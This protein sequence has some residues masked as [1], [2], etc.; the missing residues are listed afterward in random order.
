[1]LPA[2]PLPPSPAPPGANV[3]PLPQG[4]G[5]GTHAG[6][7]GGVHGGGHGS[8]YGS[9]LGAVPGPGRTATPQPAALPPGTASAPLP[10]SGPS[11]ATA[12][13]A[14]A[15][16]PQL[17]LPATADRAAAALANGASVLPGAASTAAAATGLSSGGAAP[18]SLV[19]AQMQG[20]EVAAMQN[21]LAQQAAIRALPGAS[22]RRGT[23]SPADAPATAADHTPDGAFNPQAPHPPATLPGHAGPA[24]ASAPRP[25][26]APESDVWDEVEEIARRM[27]PLAPPPGTGTGLPSAPSVWLAA[28]GLFAGLFLFIVLSS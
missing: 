23:H 22:T 5:A 8:A 2:L 11:G 24:P 18:M 4:A 27:A 1:M 20:G 17:A 3:L 14:G 13:L 19:A 9:A 7:L 21:L 10:G 16:T 28:G 26:A 25:A 15:T 12:S 6:P